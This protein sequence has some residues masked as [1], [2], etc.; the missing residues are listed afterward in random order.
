MIRPGNE[1]DIR[2]REVEVGIKEGV[3]R[4]VPEAVGAAGE[5]EIFGTEFDGLAQH[6]EGGSILMS[7]GFGGVHRTRF[8]QAEAGCA[9]TRVKPEAQRRRRCVGMLSVRWA[10]ESFSRLSSLRIWP[11]AW[12]AHGPLLS[13]RTYA[14]QC[15]KARRRSPLR[16]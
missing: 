16:S 1:V 11:R 6:G 7:S 2:R 13:R 14:C 4:D 5:P 3:V 9:A 10:I 15:V 12:S 8:T